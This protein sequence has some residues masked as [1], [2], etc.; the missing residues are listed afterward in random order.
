MEYTLKTRVGRPP[1]GRSKVIAVAKTA[2]I[3]VDLVNDFVSGAFGSDS[4]KSV[5][6]R[7]GDFMK[8]LPDGVDRVFTLDTHIRDDP[9][10]RVWGEHCLMGTWGSKQ[11]DNLADIGGYRITKRH[12]DA[13]YDTD[14]DGYLRAKSI[15]TLYI[16]GI[17]TDICVLHTAAGAFFRYYNISVISD[18]CAAISP[19]RHLEALSFMERNYG[20]RILNSKEALE[21]LNNA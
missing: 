4:A 20:C 3:V 1:G 17:S 13:F 19:E 8:S 9:E 6:V 12:F 5:S 10:F 7:I 11:V 16:L 14:L 2:V 18:L 15:G 21:E